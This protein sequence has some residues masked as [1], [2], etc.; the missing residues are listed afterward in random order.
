MENEQPE[1]KSYSEK[2]TELVKSYGIENVTPRRVGTMIVAHEI[3]GLSW[4]VGAWALCYRL[5]V[6]PRVVSVLPKSVGS[7]YTTGEIWAQRKL[8]RFPWLSR[9]GDPTRVVTSGA[10][11][12]V[13]RKILLPVSIPAKVWLAYYV[14]GLGEKE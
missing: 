10:E 6:T 2:F 13:L 7:W 14:S 9:L 11:S 12:C 1:K 5:R 4:L 8:T 3:L